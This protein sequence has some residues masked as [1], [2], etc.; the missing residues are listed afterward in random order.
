M[1]ILVC[2]REVPDPIDAPPI[3]SPQAVHSFLAPRLAGKEVIEVGTRHGDGM[4]CY[5]QFA[6]LATAIEYAPEYCK[7]LERRSASLRW[8]FNVICSDYR[9]TR[10]DADVIT[11][12]EQMPLRNTEALATLHGEARSLVTSFLDQL[13]PATNRRVLS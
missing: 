7:S 9:R 6:K 2:E 11:W 5:S 1:D 10:I 8:K 4:A 12:W 3:R 13:R